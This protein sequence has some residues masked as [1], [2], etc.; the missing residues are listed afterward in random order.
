[1]V[2]F[3]LLNGGAAL[4]AI[5]VGVTT[6]GAAG[7][8]QVLFAALCVY[9][10][11][12]HSV[13]LL[14]GLAGYLTVGGVALLVALAVAVAGFVHR[15]QRAPSHRQPS[16]PFRITATAMYSVLAAMAVGSVWAWPHL[17]EA[18]RL[19]LWDDYTYHMVYPALWLRD[20]A[21][22]VPTPSRV[23]TMQAWYPLSA[24]LVSA[25]FMLPF[26][27]ARGEALAWVSLTGPLYAAIFATG[28]A[29]LLARVGCSPTSWAPVVVLFL[30]SQ[31]VGIMGSSFSDA[32]LAL[33]VVLFA[34][35]V[36]A[37]PC[38]AEG[39]R[40]A[41]TEAWYAG[42]LTGIALGIK[43]SAAIPALIILA[44]SMLRAAAPSP[45][46]RML[47]AIRT[48][49]IF[50]V[51][52]TVTGGYWYLRNVVKMGN[53]VYPAAFLI[54]PGATFP[55]TSLVEYGRR[56][57][58]GRAIA[59]ALDV[60]LNWPRAHG[61]MAV[62][63]LVGLAGWLGWP[64]SRLTRAQVHFGLGALAIASAVLILLPS[65]P[66]SAGNAMTFRAGFVHWD[67]M[68]YVALVAMLGWAALGF[69]I[70]AGAGRL[71]ALGGVVVTSAGLLASPDPLLHSPVLLVAGAL[72]AVIASRVHD[73]VPRWSRAARGYCGTRF[74]VAVRGDVLAAAGVAL[75]I[76]GLVLWRHDAKAAATSAAIYGERFF[77]SAARVL[78]AEPS[79][80]RVAVYGDQS[81]F[82][83]VGA[84]GHLDPVRLDQDGRVATAPI[85]DA[86]E[87]GALAVD[88][89]TFV[90]NL[91]AS[92]VR[93]VVVVHL[94]HPGRSAERPSQ[95]RALEASAEARLLSRGEAVTV[96]AIKG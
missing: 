27:G 67:S 30:T 38:E 40:R 10:A 11:L 87:P 36:F 62:A 78:D 60:Y 56:Y 25:W 1:M 15:T 8:A 5:L 14:S 32:D 35:F 59:D 51:S 85:A 71:R 79:G 18:T 3:V 41:T 65:T 52:W 47:N 80:T 20:H 66:Y 93:L 22:V 4:A 74:M 81:V 95:E 28:T 77:G 73:R 69:L 9:L 23:F 39:R 61:V 6:H 24:S 31:R 63:G 33:A 94:P 42:S 84:R 50:A 29:A 58:I 70:D 72:G 16:E 34:A 17:S 7:I 92:G 46:S 83:T 26:Q 49:V 55:E 91:Q 48:G 54:G 53:P 76:A 19:W 13:V 89:A 57:G 86:M 37:I 64:R 2:T 90:A 21:I 82:L 88:P 75:I 43:V 44:I 45:R 96:W 12:I 68:R